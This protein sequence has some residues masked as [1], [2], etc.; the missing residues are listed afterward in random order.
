MDNYGEKTALVNSQRPPVKAGWIC[1]IGAWALFLIPMP[2]IGVIGWALNLAAFIISIIVMVKGRVGAGVAQ[3]V[4]ALA[5]SPI[6][7]FIGLGILGHF[8]W[9]R[10]R[11]NHLWV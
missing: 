5:V 2:G 9:S 10:P 3:M 8:L 4:C 1:L 7:Y 6:I 11:I